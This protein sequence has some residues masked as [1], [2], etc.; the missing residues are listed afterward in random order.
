[1][2]ISESESYRK[3]I[4]ILV[5]S[6]FALVAD[7]LKQLLESK[8]E[9]RIVDFASTSEE[10]AEQL[11]KNEIPVILLHLVE[12]QFDPTKEMAQLLAKS[13]NTKL[14]VL[15]DLTDSMDQTKLLKLGASGIVGTHQKEEVLIRAIR[16]VSDGGVWFS[17]TVMAQLLG[18]GTNGNGNSN[19]HNGKL[20]YQ[21]LTPRELEVVEAIAVGLSNKDI[22]DQLIISEATVRHHLSSVYSK[23]YVSD[24][25]N[26]VIYA[27]QTQI[28]RTDV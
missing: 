21:A 14:L 1:M 22:A 9:I 15:S 25:L 11:A 27:Y 6:K 7:C 17:Q 16:Q 19:G 28:V 12:D 18:N 3:T 13:A 10:I 5:F 23:L 8:S 4:K 24:R 20:K 2:S 26:L